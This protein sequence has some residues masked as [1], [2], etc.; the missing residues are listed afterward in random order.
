MS[1]AQVQEATKIQRRYL[2]AIENGNFDVLPGHFYVRAFIKSYAEA[3]GLDAD[4]LIQQ[5]GSELPAPPKVEEAPTPLRQNRQSHKEKSG[6]SSKWISRILLY[7]FAILV[8]GVIYASVNY[9]LKD[10]E[11]PAPQTTAPKEQKQAE[12][13]RD[14][15]VPPPDNP[16]TKQ[17]QQQAAQ[18]AQPAVSGKVTPQPKTGST[19]NFELTGADKI[20]VKVT[21]KS[22]DHWMDIAG[23]GGVI[24]QQTI[25]EG[26]SATFEVP[27][28]KGN[29]A[30][31]RIVRARDVE[32]MINGQPIDTSEAKANNSQRI[33]IVRK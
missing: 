17:P 3:V 31:L 10:K 16:Q 5:H 27:A 12:K 13:S 19:M 25:Q 32:V 1:L 15:F 30:R 8:L 21:A 9:F 2:E 11:S 29:E 22:G 24:A 33:K 18:P 14:I 20:I 28:D 7:L 4:E 26:Q 23:T 6:N